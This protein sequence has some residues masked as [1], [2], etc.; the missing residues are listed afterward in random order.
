M[1]YKGPASAAG[2]LLAEC[3]VPSTNLVELIVQLSASGRKL[4]HRKHKLLEP[5]PQGM[6][7]AQRLDALCR[8][9]RRRTQFPEKHCEKHKNCSYFPRFF[10]VRNTDYTSLEMTKSD[11]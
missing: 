5:A 11:L 9:R 8:I 4:S 7:A 2:P 6:G 10:G 1:I 3:A